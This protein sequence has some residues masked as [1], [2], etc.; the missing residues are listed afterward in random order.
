MNNYYVKK[1]VTND[2]VFL[3]VDDNI[4]SQFFV[5]V[6]TDKEFIENKVAEFFNK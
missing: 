1:G 6:G 5:R 2:A 4:V 3:T